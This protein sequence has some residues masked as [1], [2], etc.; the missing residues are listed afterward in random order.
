MKIINP[1]EVPATE[2]HG[3]LLG[4]IAPRPIAFASTVDNAGNVNLSP[5][6]YFNLFGTN[7]A[8]LIFSPSRRVRGNTNKHTLEN[9]R[10][11]KEVVI[12]MVNFSMVEQMSLASTE[13]DK[14]VNEF[15]K[16]G[17]TPVDCIRVRPPR[18]KESPAAFECIVKDIIET[19]KEGGAGNLIICEVVLLHIA[20]SILDDENK[21]DPYKLDAVARMGGDFYCRAQGEAIFKIPKP[22]R[23]KGMGIDQ[24][25]PSI[26][27]SKVLT[28]NNLARLAG[29]ESVPEDHD[30]QM[31]K[32]ELLYNQIRDA[33][34]KNS[35]QF[36][37]LV[38]QH[39]KVL[40]E[41][42]S[43]NTAWLLLL[44]C[45]DL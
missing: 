30:V 23:Y 6:S 28:G 45:Q 37:I 10:E 19:G 2:L 9:V 21:I 4:A 32:K 40:V 44:A 41:G 36:E 35:Q 22:T 7:P 31:F 17:F 39:A 3:Y 18:V 14:G 33:K 34:V 5:F 24:L 16:S 43:V 20:E 38:H 25:P 8:T 12:N 1:K 26:R 13:Y 15:L 29:V 11:V 42:G 27:K